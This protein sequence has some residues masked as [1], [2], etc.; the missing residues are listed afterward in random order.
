MPVFV[1]QLKYTLENTAASTVEPDY[2]KGNIFQRVTCFIRFR[3]ETW[4]N[5]SN[6][7]TLSFGN[8]RYRTPD[9]IVDDTLYN[10]FDVFDVGD[11]IVIS[12][13]SGTGNNGTFLIS[14][15]LNDGEIRVTDSAGAAVTLSV[16]DE[17]GA[18]ILLDQD[19]ENIT[20]DFG[21][22]ENSEAINF[23]SKVSNDLMRYQIESA[24][25]TPIPA[26]PTA[27]RPQ[28]KD[29]WITGD[30][31]IVNVTTSG[32]RDQKSYYY[33]ITHNF[34][35]HPYYLPSQ[36]DDLIPVSGNSI[37]PK[38]FRD[39]KC[40][41]HV[42]RI[43]AYREAQEPN[44]FQEVQFE[45]NLG[46][47]GWFDEE[48]NGRDPVFSADNIAYSGAFTALDL[49]Q[50]VDL[51]FDINVD[52]SI[53]TGTPE[54]IT[55]CFIG[56]PEKD[57]DISNNNVT[58]DRNYPFDFCQAQQGAGAANG[59]NFGTTWQIIENMTVTPGTNMVSVSA[60]FSFGSDATTKMNSY[61]NGGYLLAAYASF[62]N[63]QN[64]DTANYTTCLLDINNLETNVP[65][66]IISASTTLIRHDKND[67]TDAPTSK[68]VKVED[69][70]VAETL[71]RIDHT[72]T[73]GFPNSQID[74]F[75]PS[76]IAKNGSEEVTLTSQDFSLVGNPISGP[77]RVVNDNPPTGFFTNASELRANYQVVR[78]VSDDSGTEYAY[79][80]KY[81]FL[82]R[83]EYWEQIFQ[84]NFP[85]G[86]YDTTQPFNGSNNDWIR[87][88]SLTSW[89]IY[90]R[91]STLVSFN[92]VTKW[93]NHDVLLTSQDYVSGT[94]WQ[95][96]QARS[97]DNTTQVSYLSNPFIIEN[98]QTRFEIDFDYT[99]GGS[100]D[101]TDVY[102]VARLIPKEGGTWI[103]NESLSSVY[104]RENGGLFLGDSNGLITITENAGTFTC[105]FS[106]DNDQLYSGIQE[107]SLSVS[108]TPNSAT[109]ATDFG[110]VWVKDLPV[111]E[112]IDFDPEVIPKEANPFKKC[113]YPLL[114][115]AD[116]ASSDDF[117][118]DTS[119]PIEIFPLQYSVTMKLEKF[120]GTN[121][122]TVSTLTN[123]KNG[124][125]KNNRN[126]YAAT[127]NWKAI[128]ASDGAGKYRVNFE[129]SSGSLYSEEWCL[130][131]FTTFKADETVRITYRWDSVIGDENQKRTRDFAGLNWLN[132]VRF[133]EAIL[134]GKSGD[135]E[136]ESVKYDNG[137][138][139]TVS[140][141][142][143]EKYVLEMRKLPAELYNL[144]LYDILLSDNIVISD[145]N[146]INA[147]TYENQEVEVTGGVQ[148]T[149]D[150]NRGEMALEIQLRD[151]W[152]NRNKYYS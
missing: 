92:N 69:E 57:S 141:G 56:L 2:L 37:A 147:L 145:Y 36:I 24:S 95:F 30:A 137:F 20:Y 86:W 111:L 34:R 12:G 1:E 39:Q 100:P 6:V 103:A 49:R 44:V 19:P 128:L 102:A 26:G 47:T 61:A 84:A 133:S 115:F 66:S 124:V 121:W 77:V 8:A 140:K 97:Y 112:I 45:E 58:M 76:I 65:D 80:V 46:N 131:Q 99:G 40:L 89:Q 25:G 85:T 60:R 144:V 126:Y 116:A 13:A 28:G 64:S 54:W 22:V 9:W 123:E 117:K 32:Q 138:K 135:L 152:D 146:S 27:M 48:Y 118:N 109:G 122:N 91:L 33:E 94:L 150:T 75:R 151:K 10:R 136:E 87:L 29:D 120:D 127:L 23:N 108:L 93:I 70:L 83:W 21:L 15:K 125:T 52:T 107:Y 53:I 43:R 16:T 90:Y 3:V 134:R 55:L 5:T 79:L 139:R 63:S 130:S 132:Q 110:D 4:I 38:Y 129:T 88:D 14:E 74:Q 114:V 148:P 142:Y 78:S 68:L 149:G 18:T 81:P 35:I 42:F 72:P 101:E 51:T 62:G 7:N 59:N 96:S 71:V 17:S 105:E 98:K 73:T 67:T 106:I 113:C 104:N 143:K 50:T 31:S 11:K 119:Y 82:F 41:K